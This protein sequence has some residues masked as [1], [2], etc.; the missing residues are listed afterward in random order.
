L[1]QPSQVTNPLD[2]Q[3]ISKQAQEFAEHKA[4]GPPNLLETWSDDETELRTSE[5]LG[6]IVD[7]V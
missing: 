2:A 7:L 5:L 6:A 3:E 4:D 1:R